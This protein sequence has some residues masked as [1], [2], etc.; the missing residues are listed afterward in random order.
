MPWEGTQLRTAFFHAPTAESPAKIT[1][2]TNIA[3]AHDSES[4]HQPMWVVD[5]VFFLS[6]RSGFYNLYRFDGSKVVPITELNN[7]LAEPAWTFGSSS[8]VVFNDTEALI[9]PCVGSITQ[10]THV[11][12]RTKAITPIQ[13]QYVNIAQLRRIDSSRACFIGSVHDG[14][15]RLVILT[16]KSSSQ[17]QFEESLVEEVPFD[18]SIFSKPECV[19]VTTDFPP[20]GA[21]G[22][23]SASTSKSVPLYC[24][25]Y[26]P[27]NPDFVGKE[28]EL[29]PTLVQVHGGP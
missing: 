4:I 21:V 13:T 27:T 14:P 5:A 18:T 15:P 26:P 11:D 22:N 10:L 19:A 1:D 17:V 6:D 29:P 28:G 9:T 7:D 3:G 16:L 20:P 23:S 8:Y 24:V 2:P 25:L 12:L